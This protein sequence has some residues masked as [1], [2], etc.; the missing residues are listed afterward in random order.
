L[1]GNLVKPLLSLYGTKWRER[2]NVEIIACKLELLKNPIIYFINQEISAERE[3]SI[4]N[5]SAP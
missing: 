1:A 5:V 2:R 3:I 4:A